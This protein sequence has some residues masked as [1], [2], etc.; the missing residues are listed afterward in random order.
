VSRANDPV[1]PNMMEAGLTIR[2]HFAAMAM[3]G[4]LA[5]PTFD[6]LEACVMDKR[7]VAWADALIA[8]LAK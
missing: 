5:N 6:A 3:Q 7:A 2:E 4:M 1:H 8:E